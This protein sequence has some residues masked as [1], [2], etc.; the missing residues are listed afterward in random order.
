MYMNAWT[1][2]ADFRPPL[3]ILVVP[4]VHVVDQILYDCAE[5]V[6]WRAVAAPE[7][8]PV[9]RMQIFDQVQPSL[10]DFREKGFQ[11]D[12]ELFNTSH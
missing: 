6:G 12:G 1:E 5:E 3:T 4:V 7:G 2:I 8:F 9:S 10:A 11:R